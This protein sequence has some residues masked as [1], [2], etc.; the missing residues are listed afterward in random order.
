M[1]VAIDCFSPTTLSVQAVVAANS[2]ITVPTPQNASTACP[3][4]IVD[5]IAK[6]QNDSAHV[7][8]S[9]CSSNSLAS[10]CESKCKSAQLLSPSPAASGCTAALMLESNSSI[11]A[12]RTEMSFADNGPTEYLQVNSHNAGA[13][14]TDESLARV[15]RYPVWTNC[16]L[17]GNT[18]LYIRSISDAPGIKYS[19]YT[20]QW[21]TGILPGFLQLQSVSSY[22]LRECRPV[23][24]LSTAFEYVDGGR[25]TKAA[26]LLGQGVNRRNDPPANNPSMLII[27]SVTV[28]AAA[29]LCAIVLWA[30]TSKKNGTRDAEQHELDVSLRARND[31]VTAPLPLYDDMPPT[32]TEID[33]ASYP[34]DT[35]AA[36]AP[37]GTLADVSAPPLSTSH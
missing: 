23:S 24:S 12:A 9:E 30:M 35:P 26:G 11:L 28:A 13:R 33:T 16:T 34:V 29:L 15:Y 36:T 37:D 2:Y 17:L 19:L 14:C 25:F 21:C 8:Y 31:H 1:G 6:R 5:T 20:N 10:D 18:G 7:Y 3:P 4:G 32:Y 22:E 27:A